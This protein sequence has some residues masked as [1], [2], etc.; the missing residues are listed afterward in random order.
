MRA[1]LTTSCSL[2]WYGR[3]VIRTALSAGIVLGRISPKGLEKDVHTLFRLLPDYNRI[4]DE[5]RD[6]KAKDLVVEDLEKVIVTAT[7]SNK[8]YH[9]AHGSQAVRIQ[10]NLKCKHASSDPFSLYKEITALSY[11]ITNIREV[12]EKVK[13]RTVKL[14]RFYKGELLI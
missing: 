8:L 5:N 12:V 7:I 9:R 10:C 1:L 2:T 14:N 3:P 11:S 6:V 13:K 4:L